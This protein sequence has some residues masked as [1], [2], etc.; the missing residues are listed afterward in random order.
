[1]AEPVLDQP[2]VM[3]GIGQGVAAGVAQHVSM[4]AK[5]EL[6]ARANGL[7]EAVD[8]VSRKWTP[9]FGLEDKGARR[10]PLQLAQ[11]AQF[12]AADGVTA[13]LPFLALRTCSAGLRPH[14]TCDHSRSAISTARKP[15]RKAT[16]IS[17]ASLWPWRPSLAAAISFSTSSGVRYSRVRI[18]AFGLRVGTFR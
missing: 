8:G 1:M 13:G 4:D 5:W 18:S 7:H 11:H 17:V 12:V 15:C 3:A 16:R 14:S 2:R 6:G 9:A 10:V